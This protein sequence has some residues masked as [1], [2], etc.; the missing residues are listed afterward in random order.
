MIFLF[1][2]YLRQLNEVGFF[3]RCRGSGLNW[4]TS[5]GFSNFEPFCF[6][7]CIYMR[8]SR[9]TSFFFTA[10]APIPQKW[11]QVLFFQVPGGINE[12]FASS[13]DFLS[14][15]LT[16]PRSVFAFA[17]SQGVGGGAVSELTSQ[18]CTIEKGSKNTPL[19]MAL[20]PTKTRGLVQTT[21]PSSDIERNPEL[22]KIYSAAPSWPIS[23]WNGR[24]TLSP[25]G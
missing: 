12:S 18:T 8:S 15:S 25:G 13:C 1:L 17:P 14:Q 21:K 24:I 16:P 6:D 22:I 2:G 4:F 11:P 5:E 9:Y 7:I 19:M 10:P 3:L 20:I 23:V